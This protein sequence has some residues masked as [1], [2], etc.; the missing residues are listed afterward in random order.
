MVESIERQIEVKD[1]LLERDFARINSTTL[2]TFG[3]I[4][5]KVYESTN[6]LYNDRH[7]IYENSDAYKLLE[8]KIF[9]GKISIKYWSMS[10]I[11]R[12]NNREH[13]KNIIE[14]WDFYNKDNIKEL[15]DKIKNKTL[16]NP[17][18]YTCIKKDEDNYLLRFIVPCGNKKNDDGISNMVVRQYKNVVCFINIKYG[19]IEIRTESTYADRI[20]DVLLY[21]LRLDGIANIGVLRN[22]GNSIEQFKQSFENAKFINSKSIPEFDFDI[23]EEDSETLLEV[24]LILDDFISNDKDES[25]LEELKNI[26]FDNC[27]NG[28]IPLLLAGLCGIG[29]STR[30]TDLKDIT[31]QPMYK[32]IEPYLN[33]QM[34]RLQVTEVETG[35]TYSIQISMKGN[36]IAF[37]SELTDEAFIKIIRNKIFNIMEE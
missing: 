26:N 20:K 7:N 36:N 29:F 33:H 1:I 12:D 14:S 6:E 30:K 17:A 2:K 11:N 19:Y 18:A 4:M 13:I 35:N 9:A 37:R 16:E 23:S 34:G 24:L 27:E 8:S 32:I 10:G 15:E 3:I 22:F 31:N 28:F 21:N 5:N 25:F